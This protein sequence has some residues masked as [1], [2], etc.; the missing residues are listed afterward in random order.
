M[1]KLLGQSLNGELLERLSGKDIASKEGKA[2]VI[3][4]VDAQEWCHPAV[5]SYYEIVAKDEKNIDIAV[6]KSSTTG[7]NLRRAGKITLL[8]TDAGVNFYIKGTARERR[9]SLEKVSFM[10]L[11][12]VEVAQLLEDQEPGSPITSGMTFI[13]PEKTEFVEVSEKV[14]Q[15]I[16]EEAL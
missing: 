5:L 1:S 8:V 13:R 6:G 2:I 10:S 4:T 15:A 3:V 7:K 14:F 12:R 16:R 11:F 9:E